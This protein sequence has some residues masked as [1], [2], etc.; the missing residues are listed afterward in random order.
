M[1]TVKVGAVA[2]AGFV[3]PAVSPSSISFAGESFGE[4][5]PQQ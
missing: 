5:S 3:T 1:R 2:S 4:K